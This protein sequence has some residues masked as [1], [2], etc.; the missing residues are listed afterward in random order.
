MII[1]LYSSFVKQGDSPSTTVNNSNS[2]SKLSVNNNSN[3]RK[4]L[5]S[6]SES[7]EE[8]I[9]PKAGVNLYRNSNEKSMINLALNESFMIYYLLYSYL[10]CVIF[11][12]LFL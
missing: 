8:E 11:N 3:N 6:S 7:S 4:K 1:G 2:S 12:F 5:D 9:K 10:G